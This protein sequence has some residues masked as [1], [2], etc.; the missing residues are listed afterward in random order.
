MLRAFDRV[1]ID[2]AERCRD[3]S[4]RR[5]QTLGQAGAD[6]LHTL[7]HHLP[8]ETCV[9]V[10]VEDDRDHRQAELRDGAHALRRRQSHHRRL[11]RE[12]DRLLH[13]GR[14]QSGAFRD[15]DHLI[16]GQ[17]RE[18]V[19]RDTDGDIT[20][21]AII[22]ARAPECQPAIVQSEIDDPVQHRP[23]S[24]RIPSSFAS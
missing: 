1:L 7:V 15:D 10:I 23:L 24:S 19:D 21:R 6:F 5:L 3:R 18:R 9:D 12:R 14:R 20:A 22:S 17:I 8:R 4:E 11:D 13:F 2:F 16:V